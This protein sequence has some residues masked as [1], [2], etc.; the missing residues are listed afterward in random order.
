MMIVVAA[1]LGAIVGSFLNALSFRL[2]TGRS[3]L[4][5]RSRCMHC[6]H[7]LGA[8]DLVPIFSFIFLRGRC[9]YCG[10]HMSW[11]YPLVEA[12]GAALGVGVLLTAPN[13]VELV[14]WFVAWMTLLFVVV[15]DFRHMIIP[16]GASGL[17]AV[18]GFIHL[19]T[20]GASGWEWAAGPILAAP[21]LLISLISKGTWMGWG[22]GALELGLG[23]LLGLSQ[24]ATAIFIAA[25]SGAAVGIVILLF[26]KGY[27]MK[28]ELPFGPF[29]VFGA[30]VAYFF[31]VD[32]FQALPALF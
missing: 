7:T 17:L 22:D 31:H 20:Q 14:V 19:A 27:T 24:G 28:S 18:L 30:G 2:G 10:A 9:R 4:K 23:S 29:L 25:W 3:V 11:Q 32:I 5:G 12:L 21:F 13:V 16:W 6:G 8:F 1:A 26:K 15:Y